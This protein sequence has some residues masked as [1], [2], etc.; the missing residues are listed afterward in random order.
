MLEGEGR[1]AYSCVTRMQVLSVIE[2]I[3]S[4]RV[5]EPL[6]K[7]VLGLE[8][9]LE[10]LQEWETN[11]A[12]HVSVQTAMNTVSQLVIEWRKLELEGWKQSLHSVAQRI[13]RDATK[14]WYLVCSSSSAA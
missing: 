3:E 12:R 6:V 4:F 10:K 9:V 1:Y 2:R 13:T 7:F 5:C 8:L 14:Y 11:A